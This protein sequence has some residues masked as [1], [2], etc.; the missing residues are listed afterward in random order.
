[1]KDRSKQN[2][3]GQTRREFLRNTGIAAGALVASEA[4]GP[5][6]V[7]GAAQKPIKFGYVSSRSGVWSYLVAYDIMGVQLAIEEYNAKGGLLGRPL[8]VI[9]E[10]SQANPAVAVQKATK[11]VE[12]DKVDCLLGAMLSA[13]AFSL[14][15]FAEQ[16]KISFINTAG[17]NDGQ[18]CHRHA[19]SIDHNTAQMYNVIVPWLTQKH[20]KKWYFLS[21]TSPFAQHC[22]ERVSKLLLA[23]GGTVLGSDNVPLETTDFSSYLGKLKA[24]NPDVAYFSVGGSTRVN[25]LKQ[26]REFGLR[27]KMEVSG[28]TFD[29][30]DAWS[31]GAETFTGV[32]VSVWNRNVKTPGSQEFTARFT[33]KYGKPPENNAWQGY[34]AMRTY[35]EAIK[36]AGTTDD[37]AVIEAI[38]KMKFD[39][40]KGRP[41]YYRSWDHQLMQPMYIVRAKKKEEMKDQWDIIELL[42]E[43]PGPNEDLESI[44]GKPEEMPCKSLEKL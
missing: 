27:G 8:E 7:H 28:F 1:M 14:S 38:E 25:L 2:D 40:L 33:K 4:L 20:G 23:A 31:L 5:F 26:F 6:V 18:H 41:L 19:F 3:A 9:V 24:T 22:T 35:G 29:E 43:M 12:K 37:K 34:F 17:N 10:D 21:Y 44:A 39:G 11:L 16:R 42:G 32:W 15:D 13:E 36:A 30:A